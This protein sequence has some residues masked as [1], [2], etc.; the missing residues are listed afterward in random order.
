MDSHSDVSHRSCMTSLLID[1]WCMAGETIDV[2]KVECHVGH[3]RRRSDD[4]DA[5]GN[6]E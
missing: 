4:G 2:N 6:K 3:H 1:A 5:E